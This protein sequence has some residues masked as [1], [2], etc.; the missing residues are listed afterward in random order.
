[1]PGAGHSPG[2]LS[3]CS[4]PE[5]C[6]A[7]SGAALAR[8]SHGARGGQRDPAAPEPVQAPGSSVA[9]RTDGHGRCGASSARELLKEHP[10]DVCYL[11]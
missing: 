5:R 8:V 2:S 3:G 4:G 7:G 1:M 9:G 11:S 6:R 10:F